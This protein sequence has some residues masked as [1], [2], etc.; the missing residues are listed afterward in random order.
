MYDKC[1]KRK[2]KQRILLTSQEVKKYS[3]LHHYHVLEDKGAI[4]TSLAIPSIVR[5]LTREIISEK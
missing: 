5:V 4:F 1:T 2:K 3:G